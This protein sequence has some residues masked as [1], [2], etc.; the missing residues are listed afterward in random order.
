MSPLRVVADGHVRQGI[1][2]ATRRAFAAPSRLGSIWGRDVRCPV[3][4]TGP[5]DPLSHA[6]VGRVIDSMIPRRDTR[7]SHRILSQKEE[8]V[9]TIDRYVRITLTVITI[10]LVA[11][12]LNPWLAAW[13]EPLALPRAEAETA[14]PKY[15]YTLPKAW[16]KLV[17]YSNGNLLLEAADGTL[18][19]V[20][21]RG[22]PPEYPKVIVQ[23]KFN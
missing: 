3:T 22:K 20:D 21:L 7:C 14:Q 19:E 2:E 9:M 18:R 4:G 10:A 11:I 1:A 16:G 5:G 23:T 8:T 12:A 15:E 17:A 6:P 13:R